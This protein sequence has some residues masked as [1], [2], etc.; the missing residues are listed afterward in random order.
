MLRKKIEC[1]VYI[2]DDGNKYYMVKDGKN[3]ITFDEKDY[4]S[5]VHEDLQL[6]ISFIND[7]YEE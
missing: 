1:F 4:V 2:S 6:A 7:I 3:I 5:L